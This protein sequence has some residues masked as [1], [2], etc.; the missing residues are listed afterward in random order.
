MTTWIAVSSAL[1]L[2]IRL[3][4]ALVIEP[5]HGQPQVTNHS[6]DINILTNL[7]SFPMGF[8]HQPRCSRQ[9]SERTQHW[10]L[11]IMFRT[12]RR[13]LWGNR[14]ASN[15]VRQGCLCRQ[16]SLSAVENVRQRW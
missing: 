10:K 1:I 3:L 4:N 5:M 9:R 16:L 8:Y 2:T 14:H 12:G 13:P 7:A 6:V 11:G 15:Q